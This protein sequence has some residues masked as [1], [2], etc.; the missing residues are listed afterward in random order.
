M[1]LWNN[2]IFQ[3]SLLTSSSV[4]RCF[5]LLLLG[6]KK[7]VRASF[8]EIIF[9]SSSTFCRRYNREIHSMWDGGKEGCSFYGK[10]WTADWIVTLGYMVVMQQDL[11]KSALSILLTNS[12][13]NYW[14]YWSILWIK[15]RNEIINIQKY[16]ITYNKDFFSHQFGK[17]KPKESCLFASDSN[18]LKFQRVDSISELPV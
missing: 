5:H 3:T 18:D 17:V 14:K 11:S 4:I 6:E 9:I 7:K 10:K 8:I 16:I 2:L 12:M 1:V 13:L 15:L